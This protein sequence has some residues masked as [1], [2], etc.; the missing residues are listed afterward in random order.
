[1]QLTLGVDSYSQEWYHQPVLLSPFWNPGIF[2]NR[3]CEMVFPFPEYLLWSIYVYLL[4]KL[5]E[6]PVSGPAGLSATQNFCPPQPW[7]LSEGRRCHRLAGP[8][9]SYQIASLRHHQRTALPAAAFEKRAKHA[10]P[11]LFD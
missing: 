3:E 4:S 1:M 11:S 2:V 10:G 6:A 7:P 9:S 8:Y 5:F